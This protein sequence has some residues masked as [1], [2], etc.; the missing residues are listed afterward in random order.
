[1]Y[2]DASKLRLLHRVVYGAA[3]M[4]KEMSIKRMSKHGS[5]MLKVPSDNQSLRTS[6]KNLKLRDNQGEKYTGG[7]QCRSMRGH[8]NQITDHVALAR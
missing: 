6:L 8:I 1:M 5:G 2:S 4:Y 3:V 7:D